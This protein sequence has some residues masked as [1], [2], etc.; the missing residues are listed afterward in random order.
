MGIVKKRHDDG[1]ETN[2]EEV[3]ARTCSNFSTNSARKNAAAI[4]VLTH[5]TMTMTCMEENATV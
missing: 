4:A 2:R 5:S 1:K 3:R